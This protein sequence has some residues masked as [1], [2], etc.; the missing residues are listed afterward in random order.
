MSVPGASRGAPAPGEGAWLC[1]LAS[2]SAGNCSVLVARPDPAGPRRVVLIDAGLSPRRTGRLLLERGIRPDEVDDI[3]F[4]HLDTDHCH[5][6]WPAAIRPGGWRARLRI[7]RRHMGRAGRAG[8]L[9]RRT[10]PFEDAFEIGGTG[11]AGIHAGVCTMAHDDL[12]VA[13][14][15]FRVGDGDGA[16]EL[17][18]ATDL[19]RATDALVGAMAGVGLL[20]IESNY[21]P[22]LQRLSDRPAFLKRRITGGAGHLSNAESA[23]AAGRIGPAGGV[24]LLHLSRQCNTPALAL[25]AHAGAPGGVPERVTVTDQ[26]EPTGWIRVPAGVRR[27]PAPVRAFARGLFDGVASG[28]AGAV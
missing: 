16:P 12:G 23:E 27:A 24:V 10:E 15:R 13:A 5:P 4:T 21:C 8:L 20:A 17:G 26:H 14:F 2:G 9:C 1:V 3:V 22:R 7:H 11:Q 25:A 18:Y 6:G 19:G 28:R